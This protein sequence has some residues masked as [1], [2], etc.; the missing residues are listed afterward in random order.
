[1]GHQ[2]GKVAEQVG[3]NAKQKKVGRGIR[4]GS[5][6]KKEKAPPLEAL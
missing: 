5:S 6:M 2:L 1:M 4:W 3:C